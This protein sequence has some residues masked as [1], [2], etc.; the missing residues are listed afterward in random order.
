MVK[1]LIANKNIEQD[2]TLCQYL[3]N[4]NGV[5]VVTTTNGLST[6]EEYLKLRPDIFILHTNLKDIKCFSRS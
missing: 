4:L 2:L 5:K 3:A 6:L 1:I